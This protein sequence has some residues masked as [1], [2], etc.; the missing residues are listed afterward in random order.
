[1]CNKDHENEL[2]V[3]ELAHYLVRKTTNQDE[4]KPKQKEKPPDKK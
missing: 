3:N 1:M 2:D 4:E